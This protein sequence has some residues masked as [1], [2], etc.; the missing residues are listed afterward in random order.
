MRCF[1]AIEFDEEVKDKISV[2]QKTL[3]AKNLF[4]GKLTE[5]E[6][7][8]LTLKFLGELDEKILEKVK[9]SLEK[10]KHSEFEAELT[11]LGV[12]SED[13]IRIIWLKVTNTDEL[14]KKIDN[15]LQNLFPNEK[16]YMGHLTIARP[17]SVPDKKAL[18]KNLEE[19]NTKI[20]KIS[21]RVT[22]F[23]LK[24]SVLGD[25]G[26]IYT[27]IEEYKLR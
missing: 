9:H 16:R 12:F 3:A 20:Q 2:I 10:I 5:K 4:N 14:Q 17:K 22:S 24:E 8:H 18:L 25:A 21:L 26:P 7:L 13:F 19:I 1:I 27:T 23:S 11:T 15:A 6:N